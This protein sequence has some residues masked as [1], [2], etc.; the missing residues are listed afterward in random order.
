[1]KRTAFLFTAM[2]IAL[3]LMGSGESASARLTPNSQEASDDQAQSDAIVRDLVQR[4][5]VV[6]D[7]TTGKLKLDSAFLKALKS[8]RLLDKNQK[9]SFDTGGG[10]GG[11]K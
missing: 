9:L 3:S 11:C 2:S 10:C 5:Y 1:V 6:E 4:G 8:Y 7:L